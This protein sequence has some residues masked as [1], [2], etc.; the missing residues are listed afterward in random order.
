[1]SL[2][3]VRAVLETLLALDN[4]KGDHYLR[5]HMTSQLFVPMSVIAACK[6][7][8][9]LTSAQLCCSGIGGTI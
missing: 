3:E 5:S 9:Q 4:L 2:P 7:V 1:M 6:E 8:R